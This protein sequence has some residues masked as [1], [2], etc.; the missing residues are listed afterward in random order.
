MGMKET[1]EG[2]EKVIELINYSYHEWA[3]RGFKV[4]GLLLGLQGG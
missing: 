1:Y 3:I 4:G 2:M